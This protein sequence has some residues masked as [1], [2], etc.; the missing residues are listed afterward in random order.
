MIDGILA[1]HC[2]GTKSFLL[3]SM[4]RTCHD[5]LNVHDSMAIVQLNIYHTAM[6][7]DT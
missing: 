6:V 1:L 5:P 2:E 3:V 7:S 4:P